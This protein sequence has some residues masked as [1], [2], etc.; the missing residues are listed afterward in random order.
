MEP[1][2]SRDWSDP[3][4][5]PPAWAEGLHQDQRDQLQLVLSAYQDTC[6]VTTADDGLAQLRKRVEGANVLIVLFVTLPRAFP[7]DSASLRVVVR[8]PNASRVVLSDIQDALDGEVRAMA[9]DGEVSLLA[10]LGRAEEAVQD[11]PI[12]LQ[13]GHFGCCVRCNAV[14]LK[15]RGKKT[16][17]ALRELPAGQWQCIACNAVDG[18][19][20]SATAQPNA[21]SLCSFCFFEDNPLIRIECGCVSCFSC[22]NTFANIATGSKDVRRHTR[23]SWY[24]IP[25]P[26]HPKVIVADPALIKL[27][28][29]AS[30]MRFN[31]FAMQEAVK[32][33][34]GRT[35]C[36]PKC[37]G[38]PTLPNI[39]GTK[40]GCA[41]CRRWSCDDCKTMLNE[42]TCDAFPAPKNAQYGLD[43]LIDICGRNAKGD[44]TASNGIT[45]LLIHGTV[46]HQVDLDLADPHWFERFVAPLIAPPNPEAL[47]PR[48]T[49][50]FHGA[51]L[52][53][54]EPLGAYRV[55]TGCLIYAVQHA[56]VHDSK[57]LA[58]ELDLF[59]FRRRV[60]ELQEEAKNAKPPVGARQ[61]DSLY[62]TC[63][64]CNAG[65]IHYHNHGCHHIGFG[66][67]CCGH[68]WCYVC[69]GPYPCNTCQLMCNE[70]CGCPLCP[71]CKPMMPC[72]NCW[73]CAM[74]RAPEE[75]I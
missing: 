58:T 44:C 4:S 59:D 31:L 7:A 34:G 41:Y 55:Y 53:P 64:K 27:L 69:R 48:V 22:F 42:C 29:P 26:N 18:I 40:F 54:T 68:H 36:D 30:F 67:G 75:F 10:V 21:D 72:P 13:S 74:C 45:A 47:P 62:K 35:C 61:K 73:G 9:A 23:S 63:R 19:V 15:R 5:D 17:V 12:E 70:F 38:L 46:R 20:H 32:G 28:E 25:C 3:W 60:A 43:K 65:V 51:T 50:I 39:T 56:R 52:P 1:H 49:C 6:V 11:V 37:C 66:K 2:P 57:A 24:G 8:S 14:A 71:D 16:L 33:L